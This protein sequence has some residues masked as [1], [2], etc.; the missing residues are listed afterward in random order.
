MSEITKSVLMYWA[1]KYP[2]CSIVMSHQFL[3]GSA[4]KQCGFV[5]NMSNS[6]TVYINK[7]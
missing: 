7:N 6:T 4:G 2:N 5:P 1:L 3:D